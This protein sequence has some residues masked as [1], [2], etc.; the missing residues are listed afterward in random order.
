M[1]KVTKFGALLLLLLLSRNL[2]SKQNKKDKRDRCVEIR[3]IREINKQIWGEILKG[4]WKTGRLR[5]MILRW[6]RR[7]GC[8]V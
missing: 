7:T 6:K 3:Q 1:E 8:G 4:L 5:G 2:Q